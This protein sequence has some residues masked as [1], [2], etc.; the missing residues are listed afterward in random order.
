MRLLL[1][2]YLPS[3]WYV[4][5]CC[6]RFSIVMY[7]C[8]AMKSFIIV[9]I[10]IVPFLL[11][12]YLPYRTIYVLLSPFGGCFCFA[13]I[14]DNSKVA[15]VYDH[16]GQLSDIRVDPWARLWMTMVAAEPWS[17]LSCHCWQTGCLVVVR[18]RWGTSV[19]YKTNQC[20]YQSSQLW[21]PW[22]CCSYYPF[23]PYLAYWTSALLITWCQC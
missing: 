22:S 11:R 7:W 23:R 5:T 8:T 15:S 21:A 13:L 17:S 16:L 10:T 1:H 19:G 3:S 20:F 6:S 12:L 2:L 9:G 14:C 18:N 4:Q